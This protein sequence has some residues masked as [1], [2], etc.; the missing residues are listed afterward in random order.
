MQFS[1][2][3]FCAFQMY[4]KVRFSNNHMIPTDVLQPSYTLNTHWDDSE[5]SEEEGEESVV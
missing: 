5:Y 2:N 1:I 3:M 4:K